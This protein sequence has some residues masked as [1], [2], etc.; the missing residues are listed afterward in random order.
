MTTVL[1]ADI[2]IGPTA[3]GKSA[4]ALLLAEKNRPPRPLLAADSMT[5]YRGMDAGTAKPDAADRAL[6]PHYGLDLAEPSRE[7]SVGDY[8]AAVRASASELAAGPAPIVVGGTGLYVKCLTE[9][10]DSA[11]P[12]SPEHRAAA[13]ALL[14]AEGPK[15]CRRPSAVSPRNSIRASATPKTRVAS[16][17]PTNSSPAATK[18]PSPPSARVTGSSACAANRPIWMPASPAAPAACTP[19]DCPRKSEPCAPFPADFPRPPGTPS[20]TKRPAAFSTAKS[21]KKRP[22]KPPSVAPAA[23]PSAR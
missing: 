21:P 23:T 11:P 22:S 2:L 7:F 13:E 18:S 3:C 12:S 10:L 1:S 9:G 16:S 5:V 6:V 19:T 20:A 14:A 15:R 4:V 17:A 8:L